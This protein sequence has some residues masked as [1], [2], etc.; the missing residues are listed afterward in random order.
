MLVAL[1]A[2]TGLAIALAA[3]PA[4]ARFARQ[5]G[6]VA[7]PN[8]D[9]PTHRR[10]VPLLGGV[11][12]LAGVAPMLAA[13]ISIEARWAALAIGLVPVAALGAYKDRV[14]VPVSPRV[15]LAVQAAAAATLWI[16]GFRLGL[17][18]AW[19]DAAATIA[20]VIVMIN[21][22][23]FLDVMDGLA[24]G[25]AA[26]SLA[27]VAI[28]ADGAVALIAA[29]LAGSAAGY[30][31]FNWPPARLF[32][33]DVGSFGIGLIVSALLLA[34][35]RGAPTGLLVAVVP[36][37]DLVFTTLS[38]A[39]AGIS[40]LRGG[41]EHL[42]LRLAARGWSVPRIDALAYA[43]AAAGAAIAMATR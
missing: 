42:P 31:R 10:R 13:A 23:N 40:P 32:M 39:L 29:A 12:I 3:T 35:H 41:A 2:L 19:L 21:A 7:G 6:F 43:I 27:V 4:V 25:V 24:A 5:H 30:L 26:S 9:V 33:G 16:G 22:W 14:E 36:L 1:A 17:S 11:A 34:S 15:Q 37:G 38:R 18:P 20:A 28:A 8:P